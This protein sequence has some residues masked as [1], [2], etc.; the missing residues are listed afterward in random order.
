MFA[1]ALLRSGL[2]M[3]E[4]VGVTVTSSQ[5]SAQNVCAVCVCG[6][7]HAHVS[8]YVCGCVGFWASV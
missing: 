2:H 5:M 3:G 4:C 1:V 8:A 6:C 7:L